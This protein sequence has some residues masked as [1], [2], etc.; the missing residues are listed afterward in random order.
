MEEA[1]RCGVSILPIDS[2]HSALSQCL[3]GRENAPLH[4][5]IVRLAQ[6]RPG[7]ASLFPRL[8]KD[9]PK[10]QMQFSFSGIKTAVLRAHK[11]GHDPLRICRDFQNTVFELI[12]RNVSRSVHQTGIRRVVASGGVLANETLR[13]RLCK[14]SEKKDFSLAY[15]EKKVLCTDNAAMVAA[16]GFALFQKGKH[17]RELDFQVASKR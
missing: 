9:L 13:Q 3:E 5:W 1:S 16:L 2:E 8:L 14:L 7:Q 12:E 6:G 17:T 11:Q 15:P 10:N 4:P